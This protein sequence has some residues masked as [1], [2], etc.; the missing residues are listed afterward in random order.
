MFTVITLAAF[1]TVFVLT[2]A[3]VKPEQPLKLKHFE[4]TLNIV[5]SLKPKGF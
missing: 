3:I 1:F 4:S 5:E 2:R